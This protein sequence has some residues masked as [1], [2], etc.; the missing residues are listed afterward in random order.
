MLGLLKETQEDMRVGRLAGLRLASVS[1]TA[2]GLL[3]R[4]SSALAFMACNRTL[5]RPFNDCGIVS[6]RLIMT[7]RMIEES[8]CSEV[9]IAGV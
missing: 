3:L 4:E 1:E 5:R 2:V 9:T 7:L 6:R 8:S